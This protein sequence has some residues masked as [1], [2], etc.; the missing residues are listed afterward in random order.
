ML[1]SE[2][3]LT[4]QVSHPDYPGTSGNWLSY[5]QGSHSFIATATQA[6]IDDFC[7]TS[8]ATYQANTVTVQVRSIPSYNSAMYTDSTF[9]VYFENPRTV[10]CKDTTLIEPT[11]DTIITSVSAAP[12]QFTFP[13]V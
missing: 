1:A 4:Y 11:F 8:L 6:E 13:E 7:G 2:Y 12:F 3:Y 10:A 9:T 5:D